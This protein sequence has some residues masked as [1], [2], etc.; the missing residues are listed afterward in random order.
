MKIRIISIG[1]TADPALVELIEKYMSRIGRYASV[2]FEVVPGVKTHRNLPVEKQ[3]A[4]EGERILR[5]LQPG[6]YI[7]LLDE[8][9]KNYTSKKFA[10]WL[11]NRFNTGG[12]SLCFIIGGPYG[13]SPSLYDRANAMVRLSDM[14][15]SHQMIRLFFVEQLYRAFTI[16]RG[17]PYHHE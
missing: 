10:S 8:K 4:E 17:E 5:K 16:I 14:T 3:K 2:S 9:G 13:F 6:E 7:V 12:K 11:Q 15:F 1:K